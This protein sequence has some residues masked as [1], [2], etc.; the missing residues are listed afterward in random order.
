ML[1][2][3]SSRIFKRTRKTGQGKALA[4]REAEGHNKE[5]CHHRK[6]TKIAKALLRF[7]YF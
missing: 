5:V 3:N 1:G 4:G 7:R 2:S 6:K